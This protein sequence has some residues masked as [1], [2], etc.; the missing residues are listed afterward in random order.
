[1]IFFTHQVTSASGVAITVASKVHGIV[2]GTTKSR[3]TSISGFITIVKEAWCRKIQFL[4]WFSHWLRMAYLIFRSCK[5]STSE[6]EIGAQT[7][8]S[9]VSVVRRAKA[10]AAR[11]PWKAEGVWVEIKLS[12]RLQKVLWSLKPLSNPAAGLKVILS[13]PKNLHSIQRFQIYFSPW[14]CTF[15]YR[16][17]PSTVFSF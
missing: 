2:G 15:R 1:M 13:T 6:L 3:K 4:N 10:P 16:W 5:H 9:R 11:L 14:R 12:V 17:D 8:K 7:G